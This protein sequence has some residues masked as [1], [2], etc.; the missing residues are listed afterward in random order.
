MQEID[1]VIALV[2]LMEIICQDIENNKYKEENDIFKTTKMDNV[3][4]IKKDNFKK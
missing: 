2:E 1:E 3:A 4:E